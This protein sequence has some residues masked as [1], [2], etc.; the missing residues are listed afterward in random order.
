M[1][2]TVSLTS[3][4]AKL[5]DAI[6]KARLAVNAEKREY[7]HETFVVTI[8]PRAPIRMQRCQPV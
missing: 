8:A 6:R 4:E 3:D 7:R 1:Q 2:K 5:I